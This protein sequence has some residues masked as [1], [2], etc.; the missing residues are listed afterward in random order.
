MG[1]FKKITKP[2]KKIAKPF[3][4][5]LGP[6]AGAGLGYLLAPMT[7]G[8]SIPASMALGGALGGVGQTALTGGHTEDYLK[9]G[10]LGGLG[11]YGAGSLLKP[12]AVGATSLGSG[13]PSIAPS[14]A[15]TGAGAGLR[16]WWEFEQM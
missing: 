14:V 4:S 5:L 12:A 2:F 8:L 10:I 16:G 3:K 7:G 1:F 6:A 13:A 15:G 11:G 9:S